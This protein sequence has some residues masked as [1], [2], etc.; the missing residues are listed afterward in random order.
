MSTKKTDVDQQLIRDLAGILNDTNLSEIQVELGD[1]KV[2]VA[3]H[4]APVQTYAAPL[5][6]GSGRGCARRR[7]RAGCRARRSFEECRAL[8]DGR[9]RLPRAL[10]R[11]KTLYRSR[12]VGAQKARPW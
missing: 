11:R 9:H 2:R 12:P 7:C 10:A 5:P 8:A 4:A 6:H 1:L 3:R